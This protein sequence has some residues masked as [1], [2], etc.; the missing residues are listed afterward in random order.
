MKHLL[1]I[2]QYVLGTGLKTI[3]TMTNNLTDTILSKSS[4]LSF[5]F[6][7]PMYI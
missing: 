4:A 3:I 6:V 1:C 5:V 7:M 2:K